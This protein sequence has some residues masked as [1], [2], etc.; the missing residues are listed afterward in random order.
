DLSEIASLEI[1]EEMGLAE[2][3]L[4]KPFTPRPGVSSP[5]GAA[6]GSPFRWPFSNTPR[7]CPTSCCGRSRSIP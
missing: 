4:T 6:G 3:T 1:Y 7:S 2:V 5:Q